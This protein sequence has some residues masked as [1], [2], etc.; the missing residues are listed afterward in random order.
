[1]VLPHWIVLLPYPWTPPT[2]VCIRTHPVASGR[3]LNT[4]RLL[5]PLLWPTA[6]RALHPSVIEPKMR[7][8]RQSPMPRLVDSSSQT[9][10]S[11]SLPN[12]SPS[13][14]NLA[15][16]KVLYKTFGYTVDLKMDA[17]RIHK[18]LKETILTCVEVTGADLLGGNTK[19]HTIVGQSITIYIDLYI[20]DFIIALD[21]HPVM[22]LPV[23]FRNIQS[24]ISS[25][26]SPNIHIIKT[27]MMYV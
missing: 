24:Q 27:N 16:Y 7:L 2:P 19:M 8:Y 13:Q 9:S 6:G 4:K 3:P 5:A 15:L 1:M 21:L 23:N 20:G 18:E 17:S 22:C 14:I 26:P 11:F 10:H 12:F 25:N